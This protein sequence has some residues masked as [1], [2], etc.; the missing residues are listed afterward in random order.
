MTSQARNHRNPRDRRRRRPTER[1][2]DAKAAQILAEIGSSFARLGAPIELEAK[3]KNSVD[4]GEVQHHRGVW[5]L[6]VS[7]EKPYYLSADDAEDFDMFS[8][9]GGWG[10]PYELR[11]ITE[12]KAEREAR[13]AKEAATRAQADLIISQVTD[14]RA[15]VEEL[16]PL[17]IRPLTGAEDDLVW[18]SIHKWE[19]TR[20]GRPVL[21]AEKIAENPAPGK[22]GDAVTSLVRAALGEMWE[23]LPAMPGND[24]GYL[25][26]SAIYRVGDRIVVYFAQTGYDSGGP[27]IQGISILAEDAELMADQASRR[28]IKGYRFDPDLYALMIELD[29]KGKLS[30]YG[31]YFGGTPSPCYDLPEAERACT[32]GAYANEYNHTAAEIRADLVERFR[33]MDDPD[34]ALAILGRDDSVTEIRA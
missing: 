16:L 28:A 14:A 10:T 30:K 29:A 25:G 26:W 8:R 3:G 20:D 6:V 24:P 2:D 17:G 13:E 22:L 31:S 4:V 21:K 11:E 12:P 7:V 32:K 33:G 9:G 19:K 1:L 34:D 23:R 18:A 15:K 5:Y 27:T